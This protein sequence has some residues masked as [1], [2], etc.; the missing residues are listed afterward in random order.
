M[1]GNQNNNGVSIWKIIAVIVVIAFFIVLVVAS[2]S[3]D[4]G[5]NG[6]TTC[7][8]CGR[9]PVVYAGFCEDCGEGFLD[10]QRKQSQ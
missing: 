1:N 2:Y 8:N 10:W 3:G 9:S 5:G 4:S 6:T 7:R